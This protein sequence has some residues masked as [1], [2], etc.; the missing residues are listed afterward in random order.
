MEYVDPG[1][2]RC[3]DGWSSPL[4]GLP[5]PI[6]SYGDRGRPLLLFPTAAADFLETERFFLVKALEPALFA[7]R[8]RVFSID[9]INRM[10]WMDRSLPVGEQARR[11]MLYARYWTASA[12]ERHSL[13]HAQLMIARR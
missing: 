11:Q 7:G 2:P 3:I 9:N 10:A 13:R 1:L 12:C 6:V 4:L 5:M 8:V